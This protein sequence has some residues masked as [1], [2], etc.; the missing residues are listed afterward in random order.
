MILSR[1]SGPFCVGGQGSLNR[2]TTVLMFGK[3]LNELQRHMRIRLARLLGLTFGK[4]SIATMG[5]LPLLLMRPIYVVGVLPILEFLY[6]L[7]SGKTLPNK[8]P[9]DISFSK[10]DILAYLK[11]IEYS[12][13]NTFSMQ[14]SW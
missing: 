2:D 8:T 13:K 9:K 4:A 12:T 1:F 6:L 11:E 3:S 5:S 7:I 10:S 14:S